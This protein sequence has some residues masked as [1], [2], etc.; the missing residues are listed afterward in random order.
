MMNNDV[1]PML[2]D[3][4]EPPLSSI[5][6]TSLRILSPLQQSVID[7]SGGKLSSFDRQNAIFSRCRLPFLSFECLNEVTPLEFGHAV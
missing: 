1:S 3:N 2:Y 7:Q 5:L 6:C 4:I